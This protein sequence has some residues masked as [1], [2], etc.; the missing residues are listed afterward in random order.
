[1]ILELK[2]FSH[3]NMSHAHIVKPASDDETVEA[4]Q[5]DMQGQQRWA[6]ARGAVLQGITGYDCSQDIR[7]LRPWLLQPLHALLHSLFEVLDKT[8]S[9]LYIVD[10]STQSY[11]HI[12]NHGCTSLL[13]PVSTIEDPEADNK[14]S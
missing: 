10:T 8:H 4:E 1:M 9:P 7:S 3:Q 6:L 11:C 12:L 13:P 5:F 2:G 14:S